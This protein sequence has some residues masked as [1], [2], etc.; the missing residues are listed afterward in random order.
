MRRKQ[1][2]C[3]SLTSQACTPEVWCSCFYG[4][5]FNGKIVG[6]STDFADY[7]LE[8]ARVAL[9]PG[10]AFGGD[11]YARLSYAI[12]MENIAEGMDRI[13]KAIKNLK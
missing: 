9:V 11:M 10:I 6:N 8:E 12:G 13:E 1:P 4:K 5:S 2:G 3:T 7:L